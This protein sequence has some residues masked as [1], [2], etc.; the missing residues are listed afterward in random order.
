MTH[1][2]SKHNVFRLVIVAVLVLSM[3]AGTTGCG[4]KKKLKNY[5]GKLN[6]ILLTMED[7]SGELQAEVDAL[8]AAISS[9]DQESYEENMV[10]L[11]TTVQTLIDDYHALANVVSPEELRDQQKQLKEYADQIELML[12]DTVRLYTVCA[13]MVNIGYLT[14]DSADQVNIIRQEIQALTPAAA[15]FDDVLNDILGATK[16]TEESEGEAAEG[17]N[18]EGENAEGEGS[19]G[20][21]AEKENA[22]GEE[23]SESGN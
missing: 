2:H 8:N 10:K 1:T 12:S 17:E 15:Y 9:R 5:R 16:E 11:Q 14:D 21:K 7:L 18:A 4:A 13:E 3:M 23:S 22:E 6:A 20:E 19:E